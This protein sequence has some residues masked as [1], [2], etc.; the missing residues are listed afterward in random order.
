MLPHF[1]AKNYCTRSTKCPPNNGNWS[2]RHFMKER[3][4]FISS[5]I[6]RT[7]LPTGISKVGHRHCHFYRGQNISKVIPTFVLEEAIFLN[8]CLRIC[9][10]LWPRASLLPEGRLYLVVV[11]PSMC[12]IIEVKMYTY[13][14]HTYSILH[15]KYFILHSTFSIIHTYSTQTHTQ[16]PLTSS[17]Q[18]KNISTIGSVNFLIFCSSLHS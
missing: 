17:S 5:H 4:T 2:E 18:H 8:H 7:E 12:V 6:S 9:L 10:I 1:K 15:S 3:W 14:L 16:D 13:T 11:D